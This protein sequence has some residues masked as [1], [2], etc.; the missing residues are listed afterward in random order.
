[1]KKKNNKKSYKE[2]FMDMSAKEEEII[3]SYIDDDYN[4]DDDEEIIYEEDYEEPETYVEEDN[5]EPEIISSE[6]LEDTSEYREFEDEDYKRPSGFNVIKII[7]IAFVVIV[8]ILIMV[9]TDVICVARYDVGPFFAI[10]LKEYKDGGTK[11]FYGLGYK[12]FKYKQIQGRRDRQIG[13]WGLKYDANPITKK[14]IDL[15]IEF[16]DDEYKT[17]EKYYRKFMRIKSTLLSVDE[18]K[19]KIVIGYN[20]EGN[21]YTLKIKCDIVEDQKN[22][23]DFKVG[24]EITI[25]GTLYDFEIAK[26][27]KPNT[28]Y[29]K[30]CFAEQ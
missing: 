18:K 12:V 29:M 7:N 17:Y 13:T 19:N 22:L 28:L 6:E 10:P 25:I 14:D 1:M 8:A 4:I 20:D 30:N 21:K 15:S 26:N 23:K 9:A 27:K 2:D 3:E 16:K 5:S 11:A 24:E